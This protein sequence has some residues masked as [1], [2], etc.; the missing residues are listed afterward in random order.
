MIL[1]KKKIRWGGF[2][3]AFLVAFSASFGF[4]GYRIAR[5]YTGDYWTM[6]NED[7]SGS[8]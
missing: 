5:A 4:W 3:L 8:C 1:S 2:L 6:T 7:K